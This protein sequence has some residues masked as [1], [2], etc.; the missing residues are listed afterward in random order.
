MLLQPVQPASPLLTRLRCAGSHHGTQA[1]ARRYSYQH[2]FKYKPIQR[3]S[4]AEL[5]ALLY[6]AGLLG[7]AALKFRSE[8]QR[9]WQFCRFNTILCPLPGSHPAVM[10]EWKQRYGLARSFWHM[11]C[12]K[13]LL[14]HQHVER[15]YVLRPRPMRQA[16]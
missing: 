6:H 16:A 4:I 10:V 15:A 3:W 14:K 12:L 8:R 1:M 5:R 9:G 2:S 11:K 13:A 7:H